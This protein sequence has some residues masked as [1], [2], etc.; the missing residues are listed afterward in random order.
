V[1]YTVPHTRGAQG[2]VGEDAGRVTPAAREEKRGGLT[3]EDGGGSG[4]S[5]EVTLTS[6]SAHAFIPGMAPAH[7]KFT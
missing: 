5:E 6:A 4:E 2:S 1:R 3:S 7:A